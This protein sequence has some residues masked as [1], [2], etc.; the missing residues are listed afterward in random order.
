M[1]DGSAARVQKSANI[2]SFG[3]QSTG[4]MNTIGGPTTNVINQS[5]KPK[6]IVNSNGVGQTRQMGPVVMLQ[7]NGN[8]GDKHVS[9]FSISNANSGTILH[10]GGRPQSLKVVKKKVTMGGH[11]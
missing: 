11:M 6:M 3:G 10:G 4:A 1:S 8:S 9:N 5:L 2:G 7:H